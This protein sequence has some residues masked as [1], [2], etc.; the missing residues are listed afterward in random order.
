MGNENANNLQNREVAVELRNI[1]KH[2]KGVYANKNINISLYKGE[3]LSILGENG[4]GKTTL[5]NM[6][7]G[8]YQP[9]EGEIFINGEKVAEKDYVGTIATGSVKLDAVGSNAAAGTQ[10]AIDA[11]KAKL[12]AGTLHVFDTSTFTVNLLPVTSYKADVDDAGD[13]V[14]ETEVIANGYFHESEYRSAPYF[15]LR[16]DGIRELND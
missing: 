7:S 8:I 5:M 2:F 12:Q 14:G 15:D 11:A 4:S 10:D 3:I 9:E 13:Y 16:I 1:S 6:L